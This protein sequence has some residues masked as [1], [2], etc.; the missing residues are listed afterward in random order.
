V[1]NLDPTDY[2][3]ISSIIDEVGGI[4]YIGMALNP[5]KVSQVTLP[6]FALEG[7]NYISDSVDPLTSAAFY[8]SD[9]DL[10][11]FTASNTA[12]GP[13]L[14]LVTPADPCEDDC[15][16]HGTCSY[17]NCTCDLSTSPK[18]GAPV[19]YAKPWCEYLNC[20][21]DC[22][23]HGTCNTDSTCTCEASWGGRFCSDYQCPNDCSSTLNQG[24]CKY[25]T[26][27]YPIE[28]VC[29]SGW[30]GS[31]CSDAISS[32]TLPCD[33]RYTCGDCVINGECG[34]CNSHESGVCTYGNQIGPTISNLSDAAYQTCKYWFYSSCPNT[35]TY[36]LNWVLSTIIV[37]LW[38]VNVGS[39]IL[40][41]SSPQDTEKRT[42]W[43]RFTRS[44]KLHLIFYQIQFIALC[45]LLGKE[46]PSLLFDYTR[47]WY[48]S[49]LAA[50]LP[51]FTA[52]V[53][54]STRFLLDLDQYQ[55]YSLVE[56]RA[57]MFMVIFVWFFIFLGA[58]IIL[59]ALSIL[60]GVVRGVEEFSKKYHGRF[61][62]VIFRV[63]D[64]SNFGIVT[65]SAAQIDSQKSGVWYGLAYL[66]YIV[67]GVVYP[68]ATIVWLNKADSKQFF[69]DEIFKIKWQPIYG[70]FDKGKKLRFAILTFLP[71]FLLGTF[72]GFPIG[73]PA[74]QLTAALVIFI[75]HTIAV[76][77]IDP[78]RDYL[79]KYITVFLNIINIITI[80]CLFG[81]LANPDIK[82]YFGIT[83]AFMLFQ[84][85]A[86]VG[87]L[88]FYIMVWLHMYE[89]YTPAQ[90]LTSI[91][92]GGGGKSAKDK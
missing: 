66:F 35:G 51:W 42:E 41:D 89:V 39:A 49:L 74:L 86:I 20:D 34:W 56:A 63:V 2:N 28:C 54:S 27:G 47:W 72:F 22:N 1:I 37:I 82:G 90:L 36:I 30:T 67:I 58:S 17:R 84:T 73:V 15:Y 48:V 7:S 9:G 69:L 6:T 59:F 81:A 43:Y 50:P 65:F 29:A 83:V 21:Y 45:G 4:A 11:Y 13:Y 88:V 40:Q 62:Y 80:C 53:G 91:R 75:L 8:Y 33:E 87:G 5:G 14:V 31:D 55:I 64:L 70:L 60:I 24:T 78:Y 16:S 19:Y 76:L 68:I 57:D 71:R 85:I 52:S 44:S 26:S 12:D 46:L 23:D 32:P 38:I 18:T 25:N 79:H 92:G 77:Q 3:A 61:F 10:L